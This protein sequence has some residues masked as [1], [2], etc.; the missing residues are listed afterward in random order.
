MTWE[1][2][3]V[4]VVT[5]AYPEPS[6]KYGQVAC[7]AGI[8]EEGEWIRLYPIDL[9]HFIGANKISKFDII[10]VE[11]KPDHDKLSRKEALAVNCFSLDFLAC[12]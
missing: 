11:V 7:T 12:F 2:K 4:T 10:E 8:T 5:K 1:K 3:K 9:T 6:S